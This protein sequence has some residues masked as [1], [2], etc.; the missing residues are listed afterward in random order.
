[1]NDQN[2]HRRATEKQILE[3][4]ERLVAAWNERQVER[5]PMLLSP[6]D[7]RRARGQSLV[8]ARPLSGVPNDTQHR[9]STTRLAP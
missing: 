1:M 5:M 6:T 3:D 2:A 7:R 8:P 9:P 4:A